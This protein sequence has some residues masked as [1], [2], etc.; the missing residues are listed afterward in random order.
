MHQRPFREVRGVEALANNKP[1]CHAFFHSRQKLFSWWAPPSGEPLWGEEASFSLRLL[2]APLSTE[3][4]FPLFSASSPHVATTRVRGAG[5]I[6][7]IARAISHISLSA[8]GGLNTIRQIKYARRRRGCPWR[9]RGVIFQRHTKLGGRGTW[10]RKG[11]PRN[12]FATRHRGR[13]GI[14][15]DEACACG[16]GAEIGK[17]ARASGT[18]ISR[19]PASQ[20]QF[21]GIWPLVLVKASCQVS[22]S[23]R[24][25]VFRELDIL[26][27]KPVVSTNRVDY[28]RSNLSDANATRAK[29]H[30]TTLRW[31][32]PGCIRASRRCPFRAG[33]DTFAAIPQSE[34]SV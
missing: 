17:S 31:S 27:P 25:N 15:L 20:S 19:A 32:A 30:F 7:S 4:P 12:S 26:A 24:P 22:G 1:V 33:E 9:R 6:P 16:G 28:R 34:S 10:S 5:Q 11:S 23:P 18:G 29:A 21:G 8:G 13:T 14:R 3:P 2:L